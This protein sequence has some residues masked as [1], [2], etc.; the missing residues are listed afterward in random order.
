MQR[1][2]EKQTSRSVGRN[3]LY[4]FTTW[5][6][7][8][9]LSF[10]ATPKI[11][12]A[13]GSQDYGIYALVLTFVGYSFNFSFGRA[14]TKFVAEYRAEEGG[15]EKIADLIS[16]AFF[17]NLAVGFLSVLLICL[18]ANWLARDVFKIAGDDFAKTVNALYLAAL[19]IFFSMQNQIF[20]SILQ[21]LHRFD[22][23]SK[24]FNL[25]NFAL[26]AGNFLLALTGF[27]FLS[28]LAWN[29]A[30]T[31]ISTI[32]FALA[33]RRLLPELKIK[34]KLR[35]D[36]SML[37][38][39]YSAGVIGYQI[40]SNFLLL[41]ESS[42]VTRIFGAQAF[43]YYVLPM[44]LAIYIHSFITS[45]LQ[46]IF[47]LAS[48]LKDEPERLARLYGKATRIVCL[49]VF[50][51][52]T[53]LI[54]ESN[55]FLTVW[56]RHDIGAD[57]AARTTNLLIM[58]TV[59]FS[60]LAVQIVSW[61][62]TD[63]LGYPS[64]NCYLFV[65]CLTACVALMIFLPPI[66][67][68]DGFALARMLGFLAIFPSVFYVEKW[69]FGAVQFGLWKKI[70]GVLIAASVC[71]AVVEKA[72]VE[73]APVGWSAFLA[74]GALGA[75]AYGLIVWLLGYINEEEKILFRR[76]LLER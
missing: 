36:I 59:T 28:L 9:V 65:I 71:A 18:S 2:T 19:I 13:L 50:F 21:G 74:A 3:A 10:V 38:V 69:F 31:L 12:G 1:E 67:G 15:G 29:S 25:N 55:L 47:P 33:A 11:V 5:L 39:R 45:L 41:F 62:M 43:T 60:F 14:V 7:P 64:Y 26:L 76:F 24:I 70:L 44:S 68:L 73:L 30:V 53:S 72:V 52:G 66:Y 61:Q 48:E 4:G 57:F 23:Y 56:T 34:F 40:L 46:V 17:I 58:H 6:L 22:V 8:L 27:S 54:V 16:A 20:S 35:R 32:G 49:F 51:L 75:I 37:I 63:G 42:R